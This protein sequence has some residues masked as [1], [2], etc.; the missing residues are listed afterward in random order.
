MEL[1]SGLLNGL[2]IIQRVNAKD[3]Q[4]NQIEFDSRKVCQGTLFVAQRGVVSDGHNYL[5]SAISNGA[6]AVV[7]EELPQNIN[8]EVVY[9]QV[10][11]SSYA[12][13]ILAKNYFHDPSSKLKLVGITGTNGKTTTATLS[14]DLFSSL[15]YCCGLISTIVNK[16]AD[17]N[18]PTERTT[19]DVLSLNKLL[20]EMVEAKCEFVFMEV[21]SHAVVQHRIAGLSFFGGV[22]SNITHDHLDYHKTFTNY[23]N[24]KK[25]FFDSLSSEAFALTNIDDKNGEKMVEST[26]ARKY[27]YSLSRLADYK[28]KIVENC[29][30]GLLL[31]INGKDVNT[32]L[33][34]R[35]NAYNLTAIYAIARLCGLNDQETLVGLS[36]LK[37]AAG[38]FEPHYLKN[39][40]TAIVDYAHTPDALDNVLSTINSIRTTGVLVTVVGCGGDRDKTKR[41][42]MASIAHKGSDILILTS[43]NP[44]TESPESILKDMNSGINDFDKV[45]TITDRREAIKLATQL[46]KGKGDIILIA[47]KG[48]ETYQEINGIKYH[49]D[50]KEEVAKY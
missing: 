27:T 18:F 20:L 9:I 12:L 2:D 30:E 48:H 25:G 23:I 42:Q 31:N 50:D 3:V 43:D 29:F 17:K 22:F 1:L 32:M 11:N 41:P 36:K 19:P 40:A 37:A 26:K 33:V 5:D 28:T 21:S 45:F 4:I 8:D 10:E 13:G 46:T 44:R 15:G 7:V 49:F 47:G 14:Y 16:I 6:V 38:R 34:G 24:A 35:F 39:G